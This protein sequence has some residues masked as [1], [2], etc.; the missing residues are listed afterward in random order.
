M[1]ANLETTVTGLTERVEELERE[2]EDLRRENGWLKEI[3]TLKSKRMAGMVPELEPSP[4][5]AGASGSSASQYA[6]SSASGGGAESTGSRAGSTG[7]PPSS[8]DGSTTD[9]E[10]AERRQKGKGRQWEM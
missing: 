7:T 9:E 8:H 5:S 3:V 6:S 10:R 2:A 4:S 1:T